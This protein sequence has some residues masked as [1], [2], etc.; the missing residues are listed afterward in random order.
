MSTSR[1]EELRREG[2]DAYA[3]QPTVPLRQE[4]TAGECPQP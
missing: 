1:L 4:V 2:G 3:Y